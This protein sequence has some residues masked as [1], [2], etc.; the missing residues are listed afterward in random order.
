MPRALHSELNPHISAFIRRLEHTG[1][2]LTQ[3]E[4]CTVM[5]GVYDR[6]TENRS[7]TRYGVPLTPT[8]VLRVASTPGQVRQEGQQ[9]VVALDGVNPE[10]HAADA[11]VYLED[12]G[13][14]VLDDAATLVELLQVY[15]AEGENG[16][17]WA[18]AIAGAPDRATRFVRPL[19]QVDSAPANAPA[20]GVPQ[21]VDLLAHHFTYDQAG[22]YYAK[23]SGAGRELPGALTQP[24]LTRAVKE[25]VLQAGEIYCYG[26]VPC[27]EAGA[28][29]VPMQEFL[30]H[31]DRV[32]GGQ[33]PFVTEV[34][35]LASRPRAPQP[36]HH[37]C[38][39]H[40][41]EGSN[42]AIP[43]AART[44]LMP[45]LADLLGH[46]APDA[47]AG[48]VRVDPQFLVDPASTDGSVLRVLAIVKEG[49]TLQ[50]LPE[51]VSALPARTVAGGGGE[52]AAQAGEHVDGI[53]PARL[54]RFRCPVSKVLALAEHAD[55]EMLVQESESV[56]LNEEAR[57]T[58]GVNLAGLLSDLGVTSGGEGVLVGIV[59]TGIDGAHPAFHGRIYKVWDMSK[60]V[61]TTHPAPDD[62]PYG[63]VY[64]TAADITANA[65]DLHGHGTHVAGTAAGEARGGFTQAGMAPKAQLIVANPLKPGAPNSVL[66]AV[67]WMLDEAD[68][69]DK[70]IV[71]N[72]SLSNN[73]RHG[74]DGTDLYALNLRDT[75]RTWYPLVGNTWDDGNI[76]VAATGNQRANRGHAHVDSLA[77]AAIA[78][79]EIAVRANTALNDWIDFWARPIPDD[80]TGCSA[81]IQVSGSDGAGTSLWRIPRTSNVSMS[82]PMGTGT[83]RIVNGPLMPHTQHRRMQVFLQIPAQAT[84]RTYTVRIMNLSHVAIEVHGYCQGAFTNGPGSAVFFRNAT[85][86]CLIASPAV[87]NGIIAVG[88]TTNRVSW[89][90][91]AGTTVPNH[92]FVL[93]AN[94]QWS[95]D[96]T[97]VRGTPAQFSNCGPVRGSRRTVDAMAPGNGI[98]SARSKDATTGANDRIDTHTRQMSGTSMATPVVT[99]IVA[100]M[101]GHDDDLDYH[102]VV[103]KLRRAVKARPAGWDAVTDGAGPLDASKIMD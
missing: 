92:D 8:Y 24:Y 74:R 47:V 68:D 100:C 26:V 103:T 9:T 70:P 84:A 36:F 1:R 37:F 60:P 77:F 58:A 28:G 6:N 81:A 2:R 40:A 30:M 59:D 66:D 20:G 72:M 49:A 25:R 33:D 82:S 63:Q 4:N 97:P 56:P 16:T 34:V 3:L 76:L 48:V 32:E 99:G 87:A 45:E 69:A 98:L 61:S 91:D 5:A 101:L 85:E 89:V 29:G 83:V 41:A 35:H 86:R 78:S 19:P 21:L 13:D 79:F 80:V 43:V 65:V 67:Q 50:N 62:F 53:P 71:I 46:H 14:A 64:S 102:D 52:A 7:F 38:F 96:A 95:A 22:A 18:N 88:A 23:W 27:G 90:N 39:F 57:S 93:D 73:G 51:G 15:D 94:N 54:R 12:R 31:I 17:A 10:Q 42:I 75:I 44:A 55:V 11:L